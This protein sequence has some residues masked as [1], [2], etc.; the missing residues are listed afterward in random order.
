MAVIK[1]DAYGHGAIECGR[2]ALEHGASHLAVAR[3][4]EAIRLRRAGI[5]AP[6]LVL[7]GPNPSTVDLAIEQKLTLSIGSERAVDLALSAASRHG[8]PLTV[9]L[10]LDTGLHRYGFLPELATG[11]ARRLADHHLIN[12]EG[13]YAHFSSADEQDARPTRLQIDRAHAIIDALE[14]QGI[15]FKYIHLPNSAA[16]ITGMCGR[17]NLFREGIASYGL[18]PSP[19][20]RLP[21]GI[22][23]VMSV[24]ANATRIFDLPKGEGVSYGL[25]YTA[26]QTERAATV[27]IGYADGLPRSLS[28]CGW[29]SIQDIQCPVLGRV[30]MDQTVVRAPIGAQEYGSVIIAGD[31]SQGEMTLDDI[32]RLSG[33]INYEIATRFSQRM[34]RVYIRDGNAAGYDFPSSTDL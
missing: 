1:A 9:H 2:V 18:A 23:P 19:D 29:F 17:S 16:T 14:Q 13:I 24:R 11:A 8:K 3:I 6:I 20:V 32:A 5:T 4:W 21:D 34:P 31:G 25:T 26:K 7:G 12:L 28:N 22:L 27:P 33:T 10:K 30:C 15:N